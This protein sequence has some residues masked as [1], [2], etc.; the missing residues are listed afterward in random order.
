MAKIENSPL[1]WS[2]TF[3]DRNRVIISTPKGANHIYC[4]FGEF[5]GPPDLEKET[6]AVACTISHEEAQTNAELIVRAINSHDALVQALDGLLTRIDGGEIDRYGA[7]GDVESARAALKL[8][9]G[10]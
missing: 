10:K 8:A 2:V 3:T 6:Q 4:L 1:P 7:H 9:R 5:V